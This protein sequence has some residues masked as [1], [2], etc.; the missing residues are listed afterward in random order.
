MAKAKT[1]YTCNECGATSPKWVGQC[2]SCSGW[3]T[4][5]ETAVVRS[6]AARGVRLLT[7]ASAAII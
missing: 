2:P 6:V 7:E 4:L 5:T 3:N 1:V